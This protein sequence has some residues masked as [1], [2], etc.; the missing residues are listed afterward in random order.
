MKLQRTLILL[1]TSVSV[2]SLSISGCI[3]A[4]DCSAFLGI[5]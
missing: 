4:R 2:A 1:V 3:N 5:F